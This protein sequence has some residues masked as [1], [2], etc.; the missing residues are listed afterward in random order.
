MTNPITLTGNAPVVVQG[1]AATT[2]SSA[3][4]LT[5]AEVLSGLVLLT[6]AVQL[7]LPAASSGNAGADLYVSAAAAGSLYCAAGFHGGGASCDTLT[8]AAN[9]GAHVYSDGTNWYVL[10]CGPGCTLD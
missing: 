5:D 2:K 6:A 1:R 9:E 10:G 7:T 8:L 3:E 4:V